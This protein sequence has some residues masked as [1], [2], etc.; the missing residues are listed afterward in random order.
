MEKFKIDNFIREKNDKKFPCYRELPNEESR[1]ILSEISLKI[2]LQG[3]PKD[4][5]SEIY[6]Q[7]ILLDTVNAE[8]DDFLLS[9]VLSFSGITP[10][11]KVFI[12]WYRFDIIDEIIFTDLELY[13][14]DIWYPGPDDIDIFDSTYSWILTVMHHGAVQIFK[15]GISEKHSSIKNGCVS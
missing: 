8:S 7:G 10:R 5:V 13:F 2:G 1:R 6:N 14:H 12:N 9:D 15:P 4:I 11:L 3:S